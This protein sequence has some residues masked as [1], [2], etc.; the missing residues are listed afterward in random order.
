M[1]TEPSTPNPKPQTPNTKPQTP[2][3]KPETPNPKPQTPNPK[4]RNPSSPYPPKIPSSQCTPR[5]INFVDVQRSFR[6]TIRARQ[7]ASQ[8]ASHSL[9]LTHTHTLSPPVSLSHTHT[10]SPSLSLSHTHNHSPSLSLSHTHTSAL[11]LIS[12]PLSLTH[13]LSLFLYTH[14]SHNARVPLGRFPLFLLLYCLSYGRTDESPMDYRVTSLTRKRHL[15]RTII[16][17]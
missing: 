3:T 2:N 5:Y 9:S 12:I 17:P 6:E 4:T 13:T 15:P 8:Q 1:N 10:P 7:H 14:H 11:F 16:R